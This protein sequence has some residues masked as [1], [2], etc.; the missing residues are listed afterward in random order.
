[1]YLSLT[2]IE[3]ST[4]IEYRLFQAKYKPDI[5]RGESGQKSRSSLNRAKN[6]IKEIIALNLT[7]HSAFITLTYADNITD[8]EYSSYEFNKF[9]KRYQYQQPDLKYLSVLEYQQRGAIHY[10]LIVFNYQDHDITKLWPHGF[11]YV[12]HIDYN[13]EPLRVASYMGKYLSKQ[14]IEFNKKIYTA[15]RNLKRIKKEKVPISMIPILETKAN[16]IVGTGFHKIYVFPKKEIKS[17]D[18]IN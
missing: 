2:K 17:L 8:H 11:S 12:K 1:M 7:I 10:H 16:A 18:N 4:F 9:I 6:N 15:S 3:K 14:S 13:H 5:S